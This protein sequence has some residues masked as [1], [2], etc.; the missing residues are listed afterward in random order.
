MN[1]WS[2]WYDELTARRSSPQ[3][4][5][6]D[7][8]NRTHQRTFTY[9]IRLPFIDTALNIRTSSDLRIQIAQMLFA[10]LHMRGRLRWVDVSIQVY[11]NTYAC[12]IIHMCWVVWQ[13]WRVLLINSYT[14]TLVKPNLWILNLDDN[15]FGL[16]RTHSVDG[17]PLNVVYEKFAVKYLL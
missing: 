8:T 14:H 6:E 2:H 13:Q 10:K 1:D 3:H 17:S 9:T 15:E 11:S 5:C 16:L 7:N 4:V 12:E